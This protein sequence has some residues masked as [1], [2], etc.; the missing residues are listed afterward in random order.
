MAKVGATR[1]VGG[2]TALESRRWHTWLS[3]AARLAHRFKAPGEDPFVYNETASVSV[4]AAAAAMAGM[5]GIAD[6]AS[7]KRTPNDRRRAVPGRVDLWLWCEERSW[8]IEFKQY[9]PK[10]RVPTENALAKLLSSATRDA[11]CVSA[12]D[13]HAR[14]GGLIVPPFWLKKSLAVQVEQRLFDFAAQTDHAWVVNPGTEYG[15]ST[16]LFFR[17]C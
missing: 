12:S 7:V 10:E 11:E 9:A 6:Y 2:T 15:R 13:A 3:Q 4:L 1:L 14:A 17:C 5:F 8:T 16:Y